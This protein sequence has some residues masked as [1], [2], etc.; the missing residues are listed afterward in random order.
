MSGHLGVWPLPVTLVLVLAMLG[1]LPPP[2]LSVEERVAAQVS[3][4]AALAMVRR[5][6]GVG[7]RTG[8]TPSGQRAAEM[9]SEAMRSAGLAVET[10]EDP[11]RDTWEAVAWTVKLGERPLAS[12]WPYG[13]SASLSETT[14][15]LVLESLRAW[16]DGGT[17]PWKGAAV[18]TAHPIGSLIDEAS[19]AGAVA[20]LT[21]HPADPSRYQEWSPI[22]DI[23]GRRSE[24]T[25]PAF[26]LSYRDGLLLKDAADAGGSPRV[27]LSL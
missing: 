20:L 13:G 15:P 22:R 26:G 18:L 11:P 25:P 5:L 14:A 19:K 1:P 9:V 6:V 23:P 7:P 27:T 10:I 4:D 3:R 16:A 21:Y 12:A 2:D 17:D 24:P 8:G